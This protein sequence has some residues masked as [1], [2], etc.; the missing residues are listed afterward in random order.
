MMS[1]Q[2]KMQASASP[3]F[4]CEYDEYSPDRPANRILKHALLKVFHRA[5][6][7][8]NIR[9]ARE[10]LGSFDDVSTT[11]DYRDEW[12]QISFDRSISYYHEAL[13]VAKL[14]LD[15]LF[16]YA[17]PLHNLPLLKNSKRVFS[18]NRWVF[19]IELI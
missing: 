16:F 15:G 6:S 11:N 1:H 4:Y 19:H 9:L 2:I 5:E 8:E 7:F 12:K 18:Y 17:L 14:I 3:Q 10:L 13:N